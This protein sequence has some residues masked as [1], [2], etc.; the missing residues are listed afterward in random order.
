MKLSISSF[1]GI[2][3]KIEARYLPDG[4]AQIAINVVAEGQSVRPLRDVAPVTNPAPFNAIASGASTLYRGWLDYPGDDKYWLS[5]QN[6]WDV[7]RSQIA[8]DVCEW[9]FVATP[10]QPLLATR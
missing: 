8:G 9:T 1:K 10:L 5:N 3:P 4:A 7:C 6:V 2:S